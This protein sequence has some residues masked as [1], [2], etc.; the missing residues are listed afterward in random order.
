[1]VLATS[2][3]AS[4]LLLAGAKPTGHRAMAVHEWRAEPARGFVRSSA[5]HAETSLMLRIALKQT[6]IAGLETALYKVSNT[7]SDLY[8]KHLSAEEVAAFVKP[9]DETLAAVSEWLAEHNITAKPVTPAGDMLQISIPVSQ[10]SNLLA[11][12]FSV[13]THVETGKT[14]IRTLQYSIPVNLKGHIDFVHPTLSFP[15]PMA[16]MP[17]FDA[18]SPK[19]AVIRDANPTRDLVPESCNTAI[20]PTCLQAI[21]NIPAT[22]ATQTSS[23]LGVSGF[24]F[25]W[26]NSLDL[27]QFLTAF[28]PD[29]PNTTT[30]DLQTLDGGVNVQIPNSAGIEANIDVQYTVGVATSV[31]VTFISV[32]E[33]G[34]DGLAGFMDII[35]TLIND[36][37]RPNVLSTSYGFNEDDLTYPMA[38]AL[39]NAYMQLGALG[40]SLIF[41]SGDGGVSGTQPQSCTTFVPTLPSDCPFVTSVGSVGGITE[42]G[43]LFSSGGFS[44][45]FDI[46]NYQAAAVGAYLDAI[47]IS[48]DGLFNRTGRGFP[49]VAVQGENFQIVVDGHTNTQFGT[50][51]STP[52]FASMI[53]LLN[54]E[55]VAAGRSPLGWLNPFLYSP[56]GRPAFKDITS[57]INPGCGTNGFSAEVG[58]D[59]LTGL[60]TPNYALLR[61]AVGL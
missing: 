27:S 10:A 56:A 33:D 47:G 6:D 37:D 12:E 42:A 61:A 38:N 46:P 9:T 53:S 50:S 3:F 54:D 20:T 15:R 14:S 49:D 28:R 11:A 24:V 51:C 4:L 43:S 29:M 57:G 2:F 36:S 41:S 21:Y 58:W 19:F 60:G 31:P 52:V 45:Y 55:L 18:I 1:M 5:A 13:F 35:T 30:F 17:T 25:E 48:N 26:A 34:E 8:G 22:P 59:P 23:K 44:N 32:G 39:C 16:L 7:D 40:T